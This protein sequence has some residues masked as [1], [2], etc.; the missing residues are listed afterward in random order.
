MTTLIARPVAG[1]TAE[2]LLSLLDVP[3]GVEVSPA[4]GGGRWAVVAPLEMTGSQSVALAGGVLAE[5]HMAAGEDIPSSL[6]DALVAFNADTRSGWLSAFREGL[7][8]QASSHTA[9]VVRVRARAAALTGGEKDESIKTLSVNITP[10]TQDIIRR[11]RAQNKLTATEQVHR[12]LALLNTVM[13]EVAAGGR[14]RVHHPDRSTS[15]I[16]LPD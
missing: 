6:T 14:I 9:E 1:A 4:H 16:V 8:A 10:E 12:G 13:D 11:R 5:V 7:S 15:D 3:I 2:V